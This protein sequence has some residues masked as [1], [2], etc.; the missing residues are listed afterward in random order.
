MKRKLVKQG[1]S[2]L[3]VSLPAKWIKKYSLK[4]GDEVDVEEKEKE[5][6]IA[7][8]KGLSEK[9]RA[10]ADVS[11]MEEYILKIFI[12]V[13][14]KK[15]IDE[16][17]L[18]YDSP[19][20][21]KTIRNRLDTLLGY[22]VVEQGETHCIIKNV[23][24]D[25]DTEFDSLL[26][27]SFLVNKNMFENISRA[28]EKNDFSE[29]E[30]ILELEKTNNKLTNYCERIL[31]KKFYKGINSFVTY[32]IVWN[33]ESIADDLRD[34]VKDI[35]SRKKKH[36]FSKEFLHSFRKVEE[37]FGHYYDLFYSFSIDKLNK[38]KAEVV[39]LKEELLGLSAKDPF[40]PYLILAASRIYDVMAS[41]MSVNMSKYVKNESET[42]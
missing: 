7:T 37:L 34:L 8:E 30:S 40:Y 29:A 9:S 38:L 1:G 39:K 26:R 14:H 31:V 27:R 17:E 42:K 23:S 11:N 12:T 41:T 32:V 2:A 16:I 28:L 10:V 5:I 21:L 3:T 13:C 33:I 15:G 22:E 35:V 19:E 20:V 25:M 4:A 36:N 18:R 6:I 24:G